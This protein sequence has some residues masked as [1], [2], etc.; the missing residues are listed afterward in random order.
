MFRTMPRGG[1]GFITLARL[2]F[3]GICKNANKTL[4]SF[5]TE[6]S[7]GE[8]NLLNP[9]MHVSA[10]RDALA[11]HGGREKMHRAFSDD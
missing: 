1:L 10:G 3:F 5:N 9:R 4:V 8:G 6:C 2:T 11:L 7:R